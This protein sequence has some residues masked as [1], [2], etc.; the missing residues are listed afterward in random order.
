M[1]VTLVA[2]AAVLTGCGGPGHGAALPPGPASSHHMAAPA[3]YRAADV[4]FADR[5]YVYLDDELVLA[6]LAATR[7]G[8]PQV[9]QL[10]GGLR[11][12]QQSNVQQLS[13]WLQQWGKGLPGIPASDTGGSWPGLPTHAEISQL[14]QLS[15]ASFDRAFLKLLIADQRGALAAAV[16]EQEGGA[17]GPA[18]Q[19]A[20][21][22]VSGGSLA[23]MRLTQLLIQR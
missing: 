22:I 16:Q 14:A 11:T 8:D 19:F 5:T 21:Q 6:G 18:R 9:R 3:A 12:V 2:V 10:A 7:S 15:P 17:F 23:I 4:T 1:T 20:A 13:G